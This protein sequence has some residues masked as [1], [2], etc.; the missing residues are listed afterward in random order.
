MCFR[1]AHQQP[2]VIHVFAAKDDKCPQCPAVIT[3]GV[4]RSGLLLSERGIG[5]GL[6]GGEEL[7]IICQIR[8]QSSL[9]TA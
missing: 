5:F 4:A 7:L 3:S 8:I 2:S 9:L 6:G 1:Q